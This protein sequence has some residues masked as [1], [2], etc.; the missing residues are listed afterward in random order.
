[1][2]FTWLQTSLFDVRFSS[3]SVVNRICKAISFGVM[4]GF[5]IVG[6]LYD[7]SKLDISSTDDVW[8][9]DGNAFKAM[10]IILMAS[11]LALVLQYGIV[12]WYVKGYARCKTPLL[13]T[14]AALFIAAMVF[15]GTCF[16]FPNG[17]NIH[18]YIGW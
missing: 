17:R 7:P 12:F 14:I 10:A 15:L 16:G 8:D 18:T 2:W 3:D 9:Y 6:I 4:T 5:A 11:R 1:M 13:S